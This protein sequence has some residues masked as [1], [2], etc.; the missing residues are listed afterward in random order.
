MQ[1]GAS[2]GQGVAYGGTGGIA[3]NM[4]QGGKIRNSYAHVSVSGVYWVGSLAGS[5]G[6]SSSI[7]NSY[8]TG[9][10][11]GTSTSKGGIAGNID[12]GDGR[13]SNQ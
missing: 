12:T 7:D 4:D 9:A 5:V 11:G 2:Q 13:R 6:E 10:V 3:G 1:G 8:G